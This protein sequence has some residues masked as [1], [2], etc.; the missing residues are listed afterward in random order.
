MAMGNIFRGDFGLFYVVTRNTG[1]LY[2]VTDVIDTY[3]YRGLTSLG[4]VGMSTAA[5][6]YQSVVGFV[7][8]LI[9][10]AVVTKIDPESAM[11]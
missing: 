11:F 5:G 1:R 9:V 7:L 3:I 10:N 8:V 2:P 6:L 4:N